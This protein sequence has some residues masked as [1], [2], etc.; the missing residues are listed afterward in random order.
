MG[1]LSPA[2]VPKWVGKELTS[3]CGGGADAEKRG[4]KGGLA[5]DSLA[6]DRA[7]RGAGAT[8]WAKGGGAE[9]ATF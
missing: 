8:K 7:K 1:A 9:W 5:L 2:K 3:L 4:K 6:G